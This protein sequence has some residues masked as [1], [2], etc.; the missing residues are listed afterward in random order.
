MNRISTCI[1]A[2]VMAAGTLAAASAHAH[3]IWFA[4]RSNQLALIYGL[5]AD[6]LDAVKRLPLVKSVA[7]YDAQG[8][9]VPASL[10]ANGPLA[11]VD[12]ANRPAVV[13][14]VLDNGTWSKTADGKWLKMGKDQVPGAV[15]SERTYKYTVALLAPLNAP[16]APLPDQTLQIVPVDVNPPQHSGQPMKLRVLYQGKPAAG[17]RVVTDWVNDC[18]AEPLQ[19]AADGSVTVKVRN[20]GLNVIAAI[21]DAPPEDPAR[22]DKIEHTATLS[23]V[24]PHGHE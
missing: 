18:E 15:L 16:L 9:A 20:Q 3:G 4:Q 13:T 19:V 24:L 8:K 21:F 10:A 7:G 12:T 14:A 23:F 5:G 22:T 17:A 6:D 2:A 1:M 11:V